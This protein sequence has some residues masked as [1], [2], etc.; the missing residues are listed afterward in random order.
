MIP[1]QR[2]SSLLYC[3]TEP[4]GSGGERESALVVFRHRFRNSHALTGPEM[5]SPRLGEPTGAMLKGKSQKAHGQLIRNPNAVLATPETEQPQKHNVYPHT[6]NAMIVSSCCFHTYN[7]PAAKS[8]AHRIMQLFG[9]G[10]LS[11]LVYFDL[12]EW[13]RPLQQSA[14]AAPPESG[15]S[16]SACYGAHTHTTTH[17]TCV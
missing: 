7:F 17:Q 9:R 13:E 10:I 11:L 6:P 16:P 4:E 1:G 5:F 2:R 12:T 14:G 3:N 15:T 8:E